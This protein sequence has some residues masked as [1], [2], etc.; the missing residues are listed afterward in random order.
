MSLTTVLAPLL[1]T[2]TLAV[3]V[4]GFCGPHCKVCEGGPKCTEC[5]QSFYWNSTTMQCE[6]CF[7]KDE[8]CVLCTEQ[9]C[10]ACTGARHQPYGGVAGSRTCAPCMDGCAVCFDSGAGKCDSCKAGRSPQDG[11]CVECADNCDVCERNGKGTCDPQGCTR[12]YHYNPKHTGSSD[13]CV[14]VL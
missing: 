5:Y 8:N 14:R 9:L 7:N 11:K 12:G 10:T 2:V 6:S 1:L 13:Y 4:Y 3:S